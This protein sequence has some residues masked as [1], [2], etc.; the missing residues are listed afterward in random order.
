MII[1]ITFDSRKE[2][3]TEAANLAAALLGK[4]LKNAVRGEDG[5]GQYKQSNFFL[6]FLTREELDASINYTFA[7][8]KALIDELEKDDAGEGNP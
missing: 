4:L 2:V 5:S 1:S 3:E 7:V 8:T 6:S